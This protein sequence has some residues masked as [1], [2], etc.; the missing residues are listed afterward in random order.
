MSALRSA[1][2]LIRD[3]ALIPA[4]W[5]HAVLGA[6]GRIE[7]AH[8]IAASDAFRSAERD[9]GL[10]EGVR[11][12]PAWDAKIATHAQAKRAYEVAWAAEI[13][14][15][16]LARQYGPSRHRATPSR[17]PSTPAAPSRDGAAA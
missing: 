12:G 8:M 16:E 1:V 15:A 10:H 9:L 5:R 4:M 7:T 3:L 14:S 17:D 11:A 6:R 2:Q 13:R